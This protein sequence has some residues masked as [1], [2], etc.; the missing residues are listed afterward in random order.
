MS[1]QERQPA[2]WYKDPGDAA[3]ARWWDGEKWSDR[4]GSPDGGVATSSVRDIPTTTAWIWILVVSPLVQLVL[5][6]VGDPLIGVSPSASGEVS[7]PPN[8]LTI[9]NTARVLAFVAMIVIAYADSRTL[10]ARGLYRR[11]GWGWAILAAGIY[12]IG[13]A[14]VVHR[15]TGRGLWPIWVWIAF[16]VVAVVLSFLPIPL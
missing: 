7:T 6:L 4:P 10:R 3:P 1:E 13:R 8:L 5:F 2:G 11:F 12:V 15:Q 16:L 14:V 9:E